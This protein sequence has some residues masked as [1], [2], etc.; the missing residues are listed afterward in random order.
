[1]WVAK[2]KHSKGTHAMPSAAPVREGFVPFRDFR[3]WY[4][5]VGDLARPG[6]AK[7]PLVV[8]HGGPG[9]PPDY[10]EPL[11]ELADTGRPIVFYDQLGCGNSD[12]PNDPSLW[13]VEFFLEELATVR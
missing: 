11:E 1:M 9:V 2:V 10:L 6:L 7:F 3:T 4:R 5:I 8:L 12:Q 13:S